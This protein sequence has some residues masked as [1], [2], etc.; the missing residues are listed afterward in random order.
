MREDEHTISSRVANRDGA[1][2]VVGDVRL[3]LTSESADVGRVLLRRVDIVHD[4]VAGEEGKSVGVAL[5]GLDHG[6]DVLEVPLVVGRAGVGAVDVLTLVRGVDI[7]HDVDADRV[8]DR[9]ALIVVEVRVEV[10]G[11]DGVDADVLSMLSVF[12]SCL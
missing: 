4:L 12:V 3:H 10:V 7:Q 1:V 9:H 6:E 11:S 2:G 5:E 8:E